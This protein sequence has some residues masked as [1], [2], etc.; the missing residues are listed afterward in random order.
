MAPP[1][2][3]GEVC[4][5]KYMVR[6]NPSHTRPRSGP[7]TE[8]SWRRTEPDRGSRAGQSTGTDADRDR[9]RSAYRVPVP[10]QAEK[11]SI[12]GT[13]DP[14]PTAFI[15]QLDKAGPAH[16]AVRR[17]RPSSWPQYATRRPLVFCPGTFGEPDQNLATEVFEATKKG[18][19]ARGALLVRSGAPAL[20]KL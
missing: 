6:A 12:V 4:V 9:V 3:V 2:V 10:S 16:S 5:Y 8:A 15:R 17:R 11:L 7:S 19:F 20:T 1:T 13:A 18:H 14:V